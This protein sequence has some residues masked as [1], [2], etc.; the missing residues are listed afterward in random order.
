M[1][2]RSLLI[3]ITVILVGILGIMLV[4]M[5]EPSPSEKIADGLNEMTKDMTEQVNDDLANKKS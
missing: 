5:N 4:Q 3:I 1:N 2:N